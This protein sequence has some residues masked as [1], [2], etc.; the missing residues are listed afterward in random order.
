M[1]ALR[2]SLSLAARDF[3]LA[4]Q[5]F[6]R[7]Q[8]R[9]ARAPTPGGDTLR[10][11]ARH[12]PGVGWLVGIVACLVFAL[13]SLA[14]RGN[15]WAPAV[16]AVVCTIASALLTGAQHESGLLRVAGRLEAA[17]ASGPG[18][19]AHGLLALFLVLAAKITLLAAIASASEVGVMAALFAGHVLSRFPPLLVA[20]WATP[21]DEVDR[22]SLR[23]AALW[24]APAL[25][26]MLAAGGVALLLVPL[27]T[28]ALGCFGM[29]RLARH[30]QP[31]RSV[32]GWGAVQQACE[33]AFYFGAA[34]A[35]G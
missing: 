6:T 3:T 1:A 30:A 5:R 17:P 22:R 29:L 27:V 14:L 4:V 31:A 9:G 35:V 25:L 8:A 23:V 2:D 19:Q 34:I 13:V 11:T 16:A 15:V 33:A 10:A 28:G 24:C 12:L 7:L 26:L 21:G 20:H 18:S 32:D